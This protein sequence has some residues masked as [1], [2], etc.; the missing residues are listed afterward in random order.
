MIDPYNPI[1][2]LGGKDYLSLVIGAS[3][4]LISR[5]NENTKKYSF[6]YID[7]KGNRCV[8]W[9]IWYDLKLSRYSNH[10]GL[11]LFS[12]HKGLYLATFNAP[13]SLNWFR[14]GWVKVEY[15]LLN[16]PTTEELKSAF[17]KLSGVSLLL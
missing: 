6:N 12:K 4:F 3:R 2:R 11:Y 1:E 9:F 16:I 14:R 15:I 13:F 8:F 10:K 17:E 7:S 5:P